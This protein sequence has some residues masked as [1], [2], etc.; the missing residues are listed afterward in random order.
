MF[1]RQEMTIQEAYN[2]LYNQVVFV[3]YPMQNMG[4][5]YAVS[6]GDRALPKTKP[7]ILNDRNM[8]EKEYLE[9]MRSNISDYLIV[10]YGVSIEPSMGIIVHYYP[11]KTLRRSLQGNVYPCL[12][13]TSPS[14]RDS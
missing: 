9:M 2:T 14:P 4:L 12:L 7:D 13:Y 8:S 6:D 3:D 1:E 11:L 5:V 10:K